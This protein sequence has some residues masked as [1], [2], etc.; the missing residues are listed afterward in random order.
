M[1]KNKRQNL[2]LSNTNATEA[3]NNV[4]E[5]QPNGKAQVSPKRKGKKGGGS[6][7]LI[8][9]G[10]TIGFGG[11]IQPKA[12][13]TQSKL[14]GIYAVYLQTIIDLEVCPEEFHYEYLYSRFLEIMMPLMIAVLTD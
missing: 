13:I 2:I 8:N 4:E 5:V 14:D 10:T 11:F 6:D 12:D 9:A 3:K 1:F 7:A